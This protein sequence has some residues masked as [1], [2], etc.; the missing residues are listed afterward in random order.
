[1]NDAQ[2]FSVINRNKEVISAEV[3][4]LVQRLDEGNTKECQF[5]VK[6]I[7]DRQRELRALNAA[8]E[9]FVDVEFVEFGDAD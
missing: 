2:R 9:F 5:I 8:A 7:C 3:A 6:Q 1:M 4:R